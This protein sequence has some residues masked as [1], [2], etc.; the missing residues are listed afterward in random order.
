MSLP[1]QDNSTKLR[2]EIDGGRALATKLQSQME[3]L[4]AQM[5]VPSA[6]DMMLLDL[7]ANCTKPRSRPPW[8]PAAA[9][10]VQACVCD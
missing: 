3:Q 9:L 10:K 8:T 2:G 7:L 5:Q 1:L 6:R 4:Q